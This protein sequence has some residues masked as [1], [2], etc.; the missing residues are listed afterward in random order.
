MYMVRCL[1][2]YVY[3]CICGYTW[4]LCVFICMWVSV[5]SVCG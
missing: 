2:L 3:V 5:G 4:L 1:W